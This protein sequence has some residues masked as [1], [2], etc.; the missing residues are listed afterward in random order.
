MRHDQVL[1][2]VQA[3]ECLFLQGAPPRRGQEAGRMGTVSPRAE[4]N[5]SAIAVSSHYPTLGGE[6]P[7]PRLGL[8][9]FQQVS[10]LG[11]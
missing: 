8:D 5:M 11:L 7:P 1:V 6:G 4:A 9:P 10:T 3:D 2:D